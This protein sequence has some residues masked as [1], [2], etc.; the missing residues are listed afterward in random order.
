MSTRQSPTSLLLSTK[1]RPLASAFHNGF[2]SDIVQTD[3]FGGLFVLYNDIVL[4]L[5]LNWA[6]QW[7]RATVT[8][9]P[10]LPF[11]DVHHHIRLR[12]G[13]GLRGLIGAGHV[14]SVSRR[15]NLLEM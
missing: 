13:V 1:K 6:G 3:I 9:P 12:V 10:G 8:A 4:V 15:V 11:T 7:M 14:A 5:I 2:Q